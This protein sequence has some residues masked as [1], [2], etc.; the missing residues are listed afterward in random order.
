MMKSANKGAKHGSNNVERPAMA[1]SL[2]L[3]T[4]TTLLVTQ[5]THA[6]DVNHQDIQP[7]NSLY[8][9]LGVPRNAT[10]LEL[11]K[12]F[13]DIALRRHPEN[14]NL[15]AGSAEKF[16]EANAAYQILRDEE[17]RLKY[18]RTG[19]KLELDGAKDIRPLSY[20]K[21]EMFLFKDC[22]NCDLRQFFGSEFWSMHERGG[23][24][25]VYFYTAS[26]PLCVTYASQW[27]KLA[28]ELHGVLEIA[29]VNCEE[30]LGVCNDLEIRSFPSIILFE[31]G[32]SSSFS[33]DINSLGSLIEFAL[34]ETATPR[35]LT[36]EEIG[37]A[38]DPI[39]VL[40]CLPDVRQPICDDQ[41]ELK[42]LNRLVGNIAQIV[43]AS[44]L[45]ED[46]ICDALSI[47]KS[48]AWLF[49][50]LEVI[51]GKRFFPSAKHE[52]NWESSYSARSFR[53]K[54]L[55][56][57]VRPKELKDSS[58]RALIDAR[59][60]LKT[61]EMAELSLDTSNK[62]LIL[63][64]K[65]EKCS[66]CQHAMDLCKEIIR[67][68]F[69]LLRVARIRCDSNQDFC[70]EQQIKSAVE[71]RMY[72]PLGYEIYQGNMNTEE[73][74]IWVQEGL[75][76]DVVSITDEA[77]SINDGN[78]WMVL[79]CV[80]WNDI[81]QRVQA[82]FR[83]I[84]TMTVEH[85]A[86]VY[87]GVEKGEN[88]PPVKPSSPRFGYVDCE[89]FSELCQLWNVFSYPHVI[90]FDRQAKAH[91][92]HGNFY[93]P[94]S[95]IDHILDVHNPPTI[96]LDPDQFE[97][98][99]VKTHSWWIISFTAGEWCEPCAVL[100]PH[101][102]RVAKDLYG[103]A[104]AAWIHCDKWPQF[105][106][107]HGVSAYPAVRM[108]TSSN[109]SKHGKKSSI[110]E[111]DF[112]D[113]AGEWDAS[114]I[115]AWASEQF[116]S[117]L[118]RF[119]SE[120]YKKKVAKGSKPWLVVYTN[121]T[122]CAPCK[123]Y[124]H[125]LRRVAYLL[126]HDNVK[127]GYIDCDKYKEL[128]DM[129]GV[130]QYPTVLLHQKDSSEHAARNL[131]V[132]SNRPSRL[133]METVA[134]VREN[135]PAATGNRNVVAVLTAFYEK[136]DPGS[137]SISEMHALSAK[138][139]GK[140]EKLYKTLEEKYGMHPLKVASGSLNFDSSEE[141]VAHLLEISSMFYISDF[142]HVAIGMMLGVL[143]L[144]LYRFLSAG[145]L[146]WAFPASR[147]RTVLVLG[148]CGTVGSGIVSA[149]RDANWKVIAVDPM[150]RGSEAF[151]SCDDD[152]GTTAEAVS[153]GWLQ[154][155]LR[156]CSFV[157]YTAENGSR[158]DYETMPTLGEQNNSKFRRF[159]E[160][161]RRVLG[162]FPS[163]HVVYIGGSWTKRQPHESSFLVDDDSPNK[164]HTDVAYEAA[165]I[166]AE[167]NAREVGSDQEFSITF[168]DWI[169]V[170]PNYS[171]NFTI[172]K[173][174]KEALSKRRITYSR[175]PYGRP[176]LH[177]KDAGKCLVAYCERAREQGAQQLPKF[178]TLLVPGYF[179]SFETYAQTVKSII[180]EQELYDMYGED[181]N[182]DGGDK[183]V[184][185]E[186]E[187][188]PAIE[189]VEQNST[190]DSLR[191]QCKSRVV[192]EL[193]FKPNDSLVIEGLRQTCLVAWNTYHRSR[194]KSGDTA[195]R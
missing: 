32:L 37:K 115:T 127:V 114:L 125:T 172:A 151:T 44:C 3:M 63:F 51:P 102:Q 57:L 61:K 161:C 128:C 157:I 142:E 55:K 53:S 41:I 169:S 185:Q 170:V 175:G 162:S 168:C 133:A 164:D 123:L 43:T 122:H 26:C 25:F 40:A 10:R 42:K 137:K 94:E 187:S 134:W 15:K 145:F 62:A 8:H 67:R 93:D 70:E 113:Y 87:H 28:K 135:I 77:T 72:G 111:R 148:S 117:K 109:T 24:C 49:E 152:F 177:R 166:A 66:A 104:R 86:Y 6:S 36:M 193:D 21:E 139:R 124:Q 103:T 144:F 29:F 31:G 97:E 181:G 99:V 156:S 16:Y 116:P 191:A 83:L 7:D 81:C 59:G 85:E 82:R 76:S 18:D 13:H 14:P 5:F 96:E 118:F 92:F 167:H 138:Y 173:M 64:Y 154:A 160:R 20:Y 108:Y 74:D 141:V 180:Q 126:R 105:C 165:K 90:Y 195:K 183:P 143:L 58:V 33:G 9:M 75:Y 110:A 17:A 112:F 192:E 153:D 23:R 71:L 158:A 12:A 4:A 130:E 184:G 30:A 38:S 84:S 1:T 56:K 159:F 88:V 188:L 80:P 119:S 35:E 69:H 178:S 22:P 129:N 171:P 106:I 186:S 182:E 11:Q 46:S 34:Q 132:D 136:F 54:L 189:L 50:S 68:G 149:F 100:T 120:T 60:R 52:S 190:P 45:Y 91:V 150:L 39:I 107:S 131:N 140:E 19:K 65:G 155:T 147:D 47:T 194:N 98:K 163:P 146:R 89:R 121:P 176:L 2:Y 101:Y 78:A 48:S 174:T 27:K 73:V 95:L 179:V 79:F